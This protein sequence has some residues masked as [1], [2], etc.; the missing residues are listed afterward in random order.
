[1][2]TQGKATPPSFPKWY[3]T[4][5]ID[6]LISLGIAPETLLSPELVTA[7]WL[8]LNKQ[9]DI[10]KT[11]ARF[12]SVFPAL[13]HNTRCHRLITR[14]HMDSDIERMAKG[15]KYRSPAQ[16]FERWF[17]ESWT[18]KSSP[19][20]ETVISTF[21]RAFPA[22]ADNPVFMKLIALSLEKN[23]KAQGEES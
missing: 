3:Y 13:R 16:A 17:E 7:H 15:K 9:A 22:L 14:E 11:T 19:R 18:P 1:M 23:S 8:R 12:D 20:P 21:N 10:L 6:A 4:V 2:N 5:A